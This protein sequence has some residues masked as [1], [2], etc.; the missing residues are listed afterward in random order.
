RPLGDAVNRDSSFSDF[1]CGR[2]KLWER[3]GSHD[4]TCCGEKIASLRLRDHALQYAVEGLS[5]KRFPN[6]AGRSQENVS[7][8]AANRSR[9]NLC[10]ELASISTALAG[11]GVCVA[12][13]DYQRACLGLFQ[14][15]TAPF[16]RGGRTLR[17]CE[18]AGCR[19][20]GLE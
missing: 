17:T 1:R 15:R 13:I 6:H 9:G 16:D 2:C 7:W 10:G 12:G 5:L 11:E 19:R 8:L 3:I 14:A 18:N 4:R 20:S